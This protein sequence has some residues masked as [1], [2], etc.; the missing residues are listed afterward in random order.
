[1]AIAGLAIAGLAIA[2][3]AIECLAHHTL[4]DSSDIRQS[5]FDIRQ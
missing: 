2:G 3:L 1:L 5:T 4:Q